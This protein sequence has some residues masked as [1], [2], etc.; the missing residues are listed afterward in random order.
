VAASVRVPPARRQAT[1]G[2]K[3]ATGATAL[4]LADSLRENFHSVRPCRRDLYRR[5]EE[6]SF[7]G[8]TLRWARGIHWSALCGVLAMAGCPQLKDDHFGR[9]EGAGGG[10]ADASIVTLVC[11]AELA[12]R[13]GCL[14]N[15]GA[16]GSAS[17]PDSARDAGTDAIADAS[18][19][20]ESDAVRGPDGNCYFAD[21]APSTWSEARTSC[22]RRGEGWDLATLHAAGENEF[23][24]ALTGYEAWIGGTDLESEGTWIW[25]R[26]GVTFFVVGAD[27]GS[28]Y[29]PWNSGEPND[30]DDSDCL[31]VLTTGLWADWDCEDGAYGHVCQRA[32]P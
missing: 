7:D 30:L 17:T 27:A 28:A 19:A 24:V 9:V 25:V 15:S 26:D 21:P 18:A 6:V 5:S 14:G 20:C 8:M 11:S 3:A 16:G 23:I 1:E 12:A 22:Q 31:R 10:D 2:D 13:G 29:T 32:L 4:A